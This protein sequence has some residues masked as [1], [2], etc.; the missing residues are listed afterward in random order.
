MP[1]RPTLFVYER[2]LEKKITTQLLDLF[3]GCYEDSYIP[4]RTRFLDICCFPSTGMF[5]SQHAEDCVCMGCSCT[6]ELSPTHAAFLEPWS[7]YFLPAFGTTTTNWSSSQKA[8][9]RCSLT[10]P[11][12]PTQLT[13]CRHHSFH[14]VLRCLRSIVIRCLFFSSPPYLPPPR[15]HENWDQDIDRWSYYEDEHS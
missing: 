13:S 3:F 5:V 8:A 15:L 2:R 10:P 11:P 9:S 6:T 12:S 7:S 1:V 14:C 4:V